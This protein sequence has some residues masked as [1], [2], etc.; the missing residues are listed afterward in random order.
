[1]PSAIKRGAFAGARRAVRIRVRRRPRRVLVFYRHPAFARKAEAFT[2]LL[3][4][5]GI[6]VELL[7]GL[8]FRMRA[9]LAASDDLWIGFWFQV[10]PEFLPANY[11]FVNTEPLSVV[12]SSGDAAWFD[13]MANAREVW[14]Y[15]RSDE[16]YV[17][18]LGVPFHFV[19][20]GYAAYY[21]RSFRENTE[22]FEAPGRQLAQDIDVLFFGNI[23]ERR[24]RVLDALHAHGL[25]VHVVS[26]SNRRYGAA[27]DQLLARSRIVLGV[28]QYDDPK[29]HIFDFGRIDVA[30]SNGLFV[31]HERPS[32][33]SGGPELDVPVATCEYEQIPEMCA[34]YLAQPAERARIA[35]TTRRWFI[36]AMDLD[37]YIP[38]ASVRVGS[39]I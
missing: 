35:A 22:G 20:L 15:R 25:V 16:E 12:E 14:G 24:R 31:L 32:S 7:S 1:L 30:L 10:R 33:A 27:L 34:H 2:D 9:L 3:R 8:S 28:H 23:S 13:A 37:S 36:A 17:R 6:D 18:R 21:E 38:Y 26:F 39:R 29:S 5:Q 4:R 19:P 11:I